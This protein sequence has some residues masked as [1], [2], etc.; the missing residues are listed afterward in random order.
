MLLLHGSHSSGLRV[1]LGPFLWLLQWVCPRTE[2]AASR[3]TGFK[4]VSPGYRE[5]AESWRQRGEPTTSVSCP[6]QSL[7]CPLG[8]Q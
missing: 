5:W 8:S 7:P 6:S 4:A 3:D 1:A 2:F